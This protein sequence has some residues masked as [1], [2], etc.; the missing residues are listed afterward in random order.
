ML[1]SRSRDSGVA[2]A[3]ASEARNSKQRFMMKS[4]SLGIS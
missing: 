3:E 2:M 1:D 4:R